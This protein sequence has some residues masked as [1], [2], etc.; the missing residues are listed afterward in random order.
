MEIMKN[1]IPEMIS[2]KAIRTVYSIE[3]NGNDPVGDV[4]DFPELFYMRR[5]S[6]VVLVDGERIELSAGQMT[7]YPPGAYHIG[8]SACYGSVY[9]ISFDS[10]SEALKAL[11]SRP[12]TLSQGQIDE[13]TRIVSS[14]LE[15]FERIPKGGSLRG[16]RKR[17]GASDLQLQKLKNSFE[18]FLLDVYHREVEKAG[19]R[20]DRLFGQICEYLS[21]DLSRTQT[22]D[23]VS[24]RFHIGRSTL[25]ALFR[26]ECGMGMIAYFNRMKIDRAKQLISE[27]KLNFTEIADSIG[28]AS[29]HYFSRLFK[30]IT[31]MTPSEYA[32]RCNK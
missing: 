10:E 13:L 22:L 18:L 30:N 7:F 21:E 14:A 3:M 2:V 28:L 4:H 1:D 27:G 16:M 15:L 23:G 29:L 32:K 24:R 31:G 19:D 25:T 17:E 6:N 12:L 20:K 5:G 26:R 11:Y 8:E 9:V